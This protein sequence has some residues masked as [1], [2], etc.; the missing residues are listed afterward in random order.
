[1]IP[2]KTCLVAILCA[3]VVTSSSLEAIR[4][5]G[6]AK[7]RKRKAATTFVLRSSAFF[8]NGDI[9]EKYTCD[10]LDMSP[11]LRWGNM[12]EGTKSFALICFDQDA[13]GGKGWVHWVMFNIPATVR[14]LKEGVQAASIGAVEGVNSWNSTKYGGPC[15]PLKKHN[16]RFIVYALNVPTVPLTSETDRNE[17]RAAMKGHQLGKAVLI[18]KYQRPKNRAPKS[19]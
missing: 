7:G 15:P 19:R 13:V 3:L 16:Y 4:R 12:P 6:Q 17:L 14:D 10:G 1:M 5:R 2:K 11:P 18:G 8:H 9:P